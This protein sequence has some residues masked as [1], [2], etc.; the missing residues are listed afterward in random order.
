MK[1]GV[2][3]S[4][5]RVE[6]KWLFEALDK[7]GVP[8]D[9]IDDREAVFEVGQPGHWTEYDVVLERSLSY[10]RGLYATQ[11]LNM[12][13]I[14]TVNMASVAAVCGDKL[15]TTEMLGRAGG[16]QHLVTIAST[17]A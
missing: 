11:I 15:A 8:Y 9:R 12:W 16:P 5:V 7:H 1:I 6:E 17:T 10:V 14:P 2:L 13:G 3:L 4:R